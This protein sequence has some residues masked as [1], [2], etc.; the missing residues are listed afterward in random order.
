MAV[1]NTGGRRGRPRKDLTP[2]DK[3]KM[4]LTDDIVNKL[5]YNAELSDE[6]IFL[7]KQTLDDT[8][9]SYDFEKLEDCSDMSI[10]D[11]N[12]EAM[13][14]FL[15]SKR[16]ESKSKTTIYNYGNELSKLFLVINKD[17]RQITAQ[18][19]REYMDYRREHDKVKPITIQNIRMY[20]MSFYKWAVIEE[21][22]LRN[23]M[24]KIGTIKREQK[25][26]DTFSDEE[27]EMLRCACKN[28]R[29]LAII[30][31]LSSTGMRVSEMTGLNKRD[32]NFDTGEVKVFGKGS[33][34]R[35]CFLT[36]RAKIHLKWYLESRVD[37]NEALFVTAKKPYTRITKNG[38]EYVLKELG[39]A[40]GLSVSERVFPHKFR[41]TLAT[42]MLNKGADIADIQHILGHQSCDTTLQCYAKME[43]D[44]IK[45]A[46]KTYVQ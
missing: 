14:L 42:N 37:N 20:L 16:A 8:F 4:Q 6:Q 38:V 23:P 27:V 46:H 5:K 34:E 36:G 18:D 31:I 2:M 32:V 43:K 11:I 29:D 30:D 21:K 44:T 40:S 39:K 28:E 41:A 26:I 13:Q 1:L 17:Y 35:I 33:K 45:K 19:I 7:L 22:I 12:N 10:Q 15:Q 9:K 24:D 3:A 25:V